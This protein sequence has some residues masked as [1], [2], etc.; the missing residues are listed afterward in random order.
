[1]HRSMSSGLF[2]ALSIL[3]VG[4]VHVAGPCRGK[5]RAERSPI[6]RWKTIGIINGRRI[7]C[8]CRPISPVL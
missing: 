2:A 8:G 5:V 1:M 7:R 4:P 6:V 3:F